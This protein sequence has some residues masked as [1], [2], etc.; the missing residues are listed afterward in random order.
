MEKGLKDLF[1]PELW[2]MFEG[3]LTK[4]SKVSEIRLRAGAG[5]YVRAGEKE[6]YVADD[7]GY[8]VKAGDAHVMT[9]GELLRML[10][11]L[12]KYSPYA[13][14]AEMRQGFLTMPGGHRVGMVGQ[15]IVEGSGQLKGLKYISCMNI[16]IARQLPGVALPLLPY[17]YKEKRP[18][19]V[20]LASPPGCGKTTYLRDLI[21]LVGEGNAY[22]PGQNISVVDERMELSAMHMGQPCMNLGGRC[23]VLSGVGKKEG[24][25]MLIRSMNPSMIAVD[26][27]GGREDM[28]ALKKAFGCGIGLLATIHAGSMEDLLSKEYFSDMLRDG[29]FSRIV[30][31]KREIGVYGLASVWAKKAGGG[32][33]CLKEWD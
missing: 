13:Y 9:K 18:E 5:V 3:V 10:E 32:F 26:E 29:I 21:R 7:G 22:G 11:H 33:E 28:E 6:Y 23:D 27:I 31:L 19:N 25:M 14:D 2:K 30:F 20:L 4:V 1:P 16:R 17:V 8:G 24:V 12:T 15:G